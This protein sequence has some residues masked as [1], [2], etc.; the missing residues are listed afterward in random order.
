MGTIGGLA[1]F[2]LF[3]FAKGFYFGV[4]ALLAGPVL[5]LWW[6]IPAVAALWVGVDLTFGS[7]LFQWVTLGNA[8]TDM[9]VPMRL[10]PLTGVHGLSFVF[11]MMGKKFESCRIGE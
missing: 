9:S 10:A 8:G 3:C 7:L 5:G 11:A 4:F 6:A 1:V 2:I